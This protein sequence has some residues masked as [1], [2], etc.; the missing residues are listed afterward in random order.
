MRNF[1]SIGRR[2]ADKILRIIRSFVGCP[3][4]VLIP[5]N[6]PRGS[7]DFSFS[8]EFKKNIQNFLST[9]DPIKKR[10]EM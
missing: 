7:I 6:S 3:S 4:Q 2:F 9:L 10:F 8:W 1:I 5:I